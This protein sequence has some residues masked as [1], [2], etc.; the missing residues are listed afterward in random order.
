[1]G[2]WSKYNF[3]KRRNSNGQKTFEKMLTFL[4]IKEMQIKTTLRFHHTP[5]RIAI[6]KNTTNNMCWQRYG[7]KEPSYTAGGK[8]SWCNRSGKKFGG[9]LKNLNIDLPYD[10]VIPLLGIYS[11]EC[12]TGYSRG[13]CT[14]MFI[15][16]LF[17]IAKL[18]KE[19]RCP[20]TDEWIK[21]MWHLY[22]MEFYSA[23]KK[24]EILSFALKWMELQFHQNI[25]LS[26]VS[27]TQEI[28]IVCSPSYVVF[29]S[30]A[31]TAMWLD[32]GHIT[33]GEHIREVW[34]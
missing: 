34:G 29:R 18:R 25:I 13:T 16:V 30:R 27:Q 1:M 32:L 9:F 3:L 4:A 15:A 5:V 28:K 31:N 14:S 7:E 12:G 24:N 2:S 20:P 6:I 21:K 8:E 19:P 23:M 11:K 22:K 10:P 17:T 33:R 26:K